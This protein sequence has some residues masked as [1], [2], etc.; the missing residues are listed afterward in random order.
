MSSKGKKTPLA[1]KPFSIISGI[2]AGAIANAV[3]KQVWTRV[4]DDPIVPDPTDPAETWGRL[5][6][7]A[8]IEGLTFALVKVAADRGAAA[9]YGRT[10]GIWPGEEAVQA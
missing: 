8:A 9:L 3:F 4:S 5:L 7:A 1:F 6:L 2:A 10:A